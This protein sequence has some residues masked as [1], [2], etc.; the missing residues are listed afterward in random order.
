MIIL[1]TTR[2]INGI[3][4]S[5]RIVAYIL[6]ELKKAIV[7]G[8]TTNELNTMSEEL[9]YGRGAIPAFKDYRGFPYSICAS[10]N[11]EIVHGFSNDIPLVAG[12]ILSIDF[13]VLY[14]GWYGDSAFTA[15][16][17][18]ISTETSRLMRVG[19]ECLYR[20]IEA[21]SAYRRVGDIS[22]AV[23][24]HAE[25]NNYNIV[26]GFVGHGIGKNL[27]E[28][29][30][31]PNYGTSH[32]GYILKPGTVIAIEPMLTLGSS[33][34]IILKDGWTTITKDRKLSVHFEHTIA[35]TE[36]GTEILTIRD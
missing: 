16:V 27:H 17:G 10:R 34:T 35:V 18:K 26:K 14:K 8:V 21:A 12:D 13:G 22:N 23:Q 20:G 1:K 30:Q 5:C 4:K 3:R 28:E 15:P 11:E 24:T 31:V 19:K 7:P 29:P 32:T 36:H 33:D 2:Q 9:C 6:S 25:K